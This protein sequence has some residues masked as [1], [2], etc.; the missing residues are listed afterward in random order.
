M[1][2]SSEIRELRSEVQKLDNEVKCFQ[3][4]IEDI[5]HQLQRLDQW[6]D[7]TRNKFDAIAKF[8]DIRIEKGH[9]IVSQEEV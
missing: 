6:D 1:F 8:L 7:E 3:Y 9:H 2:N 5:R 4:T